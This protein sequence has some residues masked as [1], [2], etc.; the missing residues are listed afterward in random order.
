MEVQMRQSLCWCVIAL[1]ALFL[2]ACGDDD[3]DKTEAAA[4]TGTQLLNAETT[5]HFVIIVNAYYYFVPEGSTVIGVV[6]NIGDPDNAETVSATLKVDHVDVTEYAIDPTNGGFFT[7]P[8]VLEPGSTH[9][10]EYHYIQSGE[11]N[12]DETVS[13]SLVIAHTPVWNNDS[14][15]VEP[16]DAVTFNWSLAGDNQ[17]QYATGWAAGYNEGNALLLTDSFYAELPA[18]A[19][20]YSFPENCMDVYPVD[21][22]YDYT[23]HSLNYAQSGNLLLISDN[24]ASIANQDVTAHNALAQKDHQ[25]S[26]RR[27]LSR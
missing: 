16:G 10:F 6:N 27:I 1:A 8:F 24:L 12:I 9:H 7:L 4:L 11:V 3:N 15:P 21:Y 17:I 18:A 20:T 25:E 2:A 23:V 5:S 26:L 13:G 22:L 14:A 19:R